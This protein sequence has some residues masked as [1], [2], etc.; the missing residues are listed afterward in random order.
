MPELP[1][2]PDVHAPEF[3]AAILNG[4]LELQE[5][6]QMLGKVIEML[7]AWNHGRA[8]SA[9][10]IVFL[11]DSAAKLKVVHHHLYAAFSVAD[12]VMSNTAAIDSLTDQAWEKHHGINQDG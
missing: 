4:F 12:E 10:D 8:V 1:P 11:Q 6:N 5:G 2:K 7:D 9:D 3:Q